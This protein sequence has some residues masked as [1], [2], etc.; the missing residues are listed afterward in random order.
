MSYR[1][2]SPEAKARYNERSRELWAAYREREQVLRESGLDYSAIH[3]DDELDAALGQARQHDN[4]CPECGGTDTRMEN[5]SMMWHDADVV[6]QACDTY[7]RMWD[8]G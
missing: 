2:P 4:A 5:Y 6:C 1:Y 3:R 7:I 8:A